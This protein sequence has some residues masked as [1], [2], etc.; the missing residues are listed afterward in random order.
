MAIFDSGKGKLHY[1]L[2]GADDA[3]LLVLSNSL[4]TTLDMWLPQMPALLEHF[5]VLR[6]DTRGHGQSEITPGPYT[7]AQLGNDVLAL[8]DHVKAPRAHFC[9]LSMGGMTGI[10]LGIHAPDRIDRLVLCNTSAAIGVPEMW[11]ARIAQVR[12]GGMAAV[13]DAVLERWF[14]NDFLAHA[15]AQVERVRA[16]LA[17]TQVEGYV[18]NCAAVRDMDQRADLGRIAT[19]TLVIGGKFDKSTPPEHGELIAKSVPG[20]RYVELNAAH[21]SNWEAAQAFTKHLVNFLSGGPHG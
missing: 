14:T 4:G 10:W 18:A 3:P 11:N 15:P 19:P 16:M 21:L 12:Q 8:M 17:H 7:I 6:Y 9:G 5:R 13:I 1:Q 2:D 20:A